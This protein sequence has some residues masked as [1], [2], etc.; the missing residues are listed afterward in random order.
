M[1]VHARSGGTIE[2]MGLMQGKTDGGAII[3][4]CYSFGECSWV[5][6]FAS[7]LW[8]LAFQYRSVVIDPTRTVSVGKVEIG[9]FRTYPEGY[10]SPEEPLCYYA[11][12]ITYFKSSLDCHLLDLLWNKYWVNNL[13]SSPLLGNG[14]YVA[15]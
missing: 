13:S 2:V 7:W 11:L 9:A 5:V 1:V 12:N 6:P 15:G 4:L 8:M 10:K 14:D 3:V